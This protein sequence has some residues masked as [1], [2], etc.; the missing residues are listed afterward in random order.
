MATQQL[1]SLSFPITKGGSQQ[2]GAWAKVHL[3]RRHKPNTEFLMK[4]GRRLGPRQIPDA[5]I[6]DRIKKRLANLL[7]SEA[8]S[9][10]DDEKGKTLLKRRIPLFP[11]RRER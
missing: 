4:G 9:P 8:G 2:W 1:L 10:S 5:P 11:L 6:L 7:K 3:E